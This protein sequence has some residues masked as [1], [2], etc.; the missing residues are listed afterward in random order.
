MKIRNEEIEQ[1]DT[2]YANYSR[3]NQDQVLDRT[4]LKYLINS[5]I[6]QGGYY[7][8]DD[9]FYLMEKI[10]HPYVLFSVEGG[11]DNGSINIVSDRDRE[12]MK[13]LL[14][15]EI[16]YDKLKKIKKDENS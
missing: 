14:E 8:D 1:Y 16:R 13:K 6:N 10:F 3:H 5:F 15:A 9:G 12:N 11:P 2:E 4:H 7:Q